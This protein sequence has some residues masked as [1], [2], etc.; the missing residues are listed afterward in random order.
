MQTKSWA[1]LLVLLLTILISAAQIFWKFGTQKLSLN[2]TS[3][4]TN[5]QILIGFVLFF[6]VAVLFVIALKGGELTVLY[7]LL[8]TSYVL[9]SLISPLFFPSDKLNAI[10]LLGI[11]II[12]VG[13]YFIARGMHHKMDVV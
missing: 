12:I 7:P 4:L 3:L 2:L 8:A 11:I 5:Y 13:V 9:V 10:K 1:V 6:V